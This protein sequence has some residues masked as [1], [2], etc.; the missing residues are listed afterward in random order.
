MRRLAHTRRGDRGTTLVEVVVAVF[1]AALAATLL[2]RLATNSARSVSDPSTDNDVTLALD[3]FMTDVRA[4]ELV[5]PGSVGAGG[6]LVSVEF[7]SATDLRQWSI[8]DGALTRSV[9]GTTVRT[10][11]SDVDVASGF[12]LL[13][14]TG[15]VISPSDV[16]AVRW[17][18]RLVVLYLEGDDDGSAWT[19]ESRA[20]PRAIAESAGCP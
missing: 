15:R 13:D 8:A 19:V 12:E 20:V 6:R 1:L 7:R 3:V 9:D 18:T 10:M 14:G 16:D 11:A 4:A 5:S 2:A 17:C